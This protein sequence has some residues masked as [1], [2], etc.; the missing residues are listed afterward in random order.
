MKHHEQRDNDSGWPAGL[1]SAQSSFYFNIR[2]FG[3]SRVDVQSYVA[4]SLG[5]PGKRRWR[6]GGLPQ[7]SF[8]Q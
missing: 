7:F 1:E 3:S 6:A 5:D 4:I 2:M 8:M